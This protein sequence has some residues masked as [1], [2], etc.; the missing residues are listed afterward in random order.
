MTE[1]LFLWI[2]PDTFTIMTFLLKEAVFGE[3]EVPVVCTRQVDETGDT[4]K[5]KFTQAQL[6]RGEKS[7][8][9]DIS[10]NQAGFRVLF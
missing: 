4:F 9:K 10:N 2:Y 1:G 6:I 7:P 3:A 8:T 5:F